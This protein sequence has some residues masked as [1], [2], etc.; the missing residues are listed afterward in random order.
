MYT[1]IFYDMFIIYVYAYVWV[2]CHR[3]SKIDIDSPYIFIYYI[4]VAMQHES[5]SMYS[6]P[7]TKQKSQRDESHECMCMANPS[8]DTFLFD[9]WLP[10]LYACRMFHYD[11]PCPFENQD[12]VPC[13]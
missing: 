11:L 10:G 5:A 3:I 1:D 9:F 12:F 4:Y 6:T 8:Q 2:V 13:G 7:D